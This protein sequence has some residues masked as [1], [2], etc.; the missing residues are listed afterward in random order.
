MSKIKKYMVVVGHVEHGC[1]HVASLVDT[2]KPTFLNQ[3]TPDLCVYYPY[4]MVAEFWSDD[5]AASVAKAANGDD[6]DPIMTQEVADQLVERT[7]RPW[8]R[9]PPKPWHRPQE[10]PPTE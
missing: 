7:G 9:S 3:G 4:E 8:Y 10:E 2:D 6:D 5:N 1:C